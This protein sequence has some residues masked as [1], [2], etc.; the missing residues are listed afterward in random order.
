[1]M[2]TTLP[3]DRI[4]CQIFADKEVMGAAA[5][6]QAAAIIRQ[7]VE[8]RGRARIL[9]ATGNS[10]L[11]M[12]AALV[13]LKNVPWSKVDAFH[14]DEYVGISADHSA[15]FR[16]WIRTRF[17]E[18]VRPGAMHYL[19]GDAPNPAQHARDYAG[20][21]FAAPVDLAFTSTIIPPRCWRVASRLVAAWP[22]TIF[23]PRL[24]RSPRLL[25]HR[26]GGR[27]RQSASAAAQDPL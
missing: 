1:M 12:M 11:E 5:A 27:T 10:Q 25:C 17:E 22:A 16:H 7:A 4:A 6:A 9:V 14:L 3:A 13:E 2:P 20:K 15:S 19:V 26:N 18:K 8:R 21:L 23:P 24:G